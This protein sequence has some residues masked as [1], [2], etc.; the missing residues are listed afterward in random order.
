MVARWFIGDSGEILPGSVPGLVCIGRALLLR[1]NKYWISD[2]HEKIYLQA[3]W[4]SLLVKLLRSVQLL[5]KEAKSTGK[6]N[7]SCMGHRL[8]MV[9][10]PL[11]QE[12]ELLQKV[13]AYVMSAV[14]IPKSDLCFHQ[15]P[16]YALFLLSFPRYASFPLSEAFK[17][18][19][20]FL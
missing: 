5:Y 13:Y 15:L 8:G 10:K 2:I 7:K 20:S 17:N 12:V 14:E 16:A 11:W 6:M 3:A 19:I 9:M 18:G 1:C 4:M